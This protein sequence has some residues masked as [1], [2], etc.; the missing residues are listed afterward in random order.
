MSRPQRPP[1]DIEHMSRLRPIARYSL[2]TLCL[3]L[4][5]VSTIWHRYPSIPWRPYKAATYFE[6][7]IGSHQ[8][9]FGLNDPGGFAA[10]WRRPLATPI[11]WP[12]TWRDPNVT[13]FRTEQ[14]RCYHC[15][16][17]VYATFIQAPSVSSPYDHEES[18]LVLPYWFTLLIY[19]A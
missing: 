3:A 2:L 18:I 14:T 12:P 9:E 10:S 15:G 16:G 4:A 1:A 7:S 11:P 19:L 6:P 17:L 5:I 13:Y 8:F